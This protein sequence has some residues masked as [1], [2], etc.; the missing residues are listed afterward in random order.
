M[1]DH[2]KV[3]NKKVGYDPRVLGRSSVSGHP[4]VL[5]PGDT[6]N[7]RAL[8]HPTASGSLENN[9][10]L[11][12]DTRAVALPPSASVVNAKLVQRW[13]VLPNQ[14]IH[15]SPR[16]ALWGPSWEEGTR[17]WQLVTDYA[18]VGFPER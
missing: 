8:Q 17:T 12:H 10:I 6:H 1:K 9:P 13:V 18:K 5:K 7:P 11:P 14:S 2:T 16:M 3:V 15:A 4:R